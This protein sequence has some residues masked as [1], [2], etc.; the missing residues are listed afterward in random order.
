MS[1]TTMAAGEKTNDLDFKFQTFK[2]SRVISNR[3]GR[4]TA[5]DGPLLA[6]T[7]R[8]DCRPPHSNSYSAISDKSWVRTCVYTEINTEI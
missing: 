5:A 1:V 8:T 4:S 3:L 6:V 2:F 7:L